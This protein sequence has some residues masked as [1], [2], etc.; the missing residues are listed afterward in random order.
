MPCSSFYEKRSI[1]KGNLDRQ[2]VYEGR[3][4][5]EGEVE[6]VISYKNMRSSGTVKYSTVVLY[7]PRTWVKERSGVSEPHILC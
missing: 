5:E 2:G 1:V 7:R 6:V 3:D 4:F